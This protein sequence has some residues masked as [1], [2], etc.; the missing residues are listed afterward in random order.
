MKLNKSVYGLT[1]LFLMGIFVST[2]S[3]SVFAEPSMI[4]M[5]RTVKPLREI[6][7]SITVIDE[8][9]I[10]KKQ[11]TTVLD[12]LRDVPALD[13][14]QNGGIGQTSSVFIRGARSEQTL[15]LIDGVEAND[16]SS[17]SRGYN[18]A[19]LGTNN[20]QRIEI[21]RGPQ[22]TLYGSDAIGGVI[23]IITK[24]GEGAPHIGVSA[25][26]G[27]FDTKKHEAN[28]QGGTDIV[29]Y[30]VSALHT[31]S[32]GF[33]AA[34]EKDGN[35]ENDGYE[36]T[37][38]SAKLGLSPH[39]VFNFDVITR[40]AKSIS[41]L[42][43]A[44]GVGGDDPNYVANNEALLLRTQANLT[45]F[46][47]FWDQ[48]VGISYTNHDRH[49]DNPVDPD[50]PMSSLESQFHGRNVKADWQNNIRLHKTNL[51]TI[52]L[53]R[54]KERANTKSLSVSFFGPFLSEFKE[55][56]TDTDS[57]FIQDQF[58][59]GDS[60]FA[61]AGIRLD[62]HS[63]FGSEETHR[64]TAAYLLN[65]TGTKLKTTY[66]TGFKAP[67]LFQLFS[68]FGNLNLNPET[69]SSW[70]VGFEQFI[71]DELVMVAATYFNNRY[72]NLIDFN[73][74]TLTFENISEATSNGVELFLSIA[75]LSNL[76]FSANH[77]FTDTEDK[78]TG[79][80]LVRRPKNKTSA[81]LNYNY[82]DGANAFLQVI[83]VGDRDDFDFTTFPATRVTL[84]AYTVVN[85][86]A[87]H[88]L[89]QNIELFGRVENIFDD[90][91]EEVKG[92]GT[93][94]V[95]GFGGVRLKIGNDS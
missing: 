6:A 45:L 47:D 7:G 30:S 33:S 41:D 34:N 17:S 62:D 58:N 1:S 75:F 52:G 11:K 19:N 13:I 61:T 42:D 26:V 93:P 2:Q 8:K 9:E 32:E 85:I 49:L 5:T 14:V 10:Q 23:N 74:G 84:D 67:T 60:F 63:R 25:E 86:G 91:Y 89:T 56:T 43:N 77:T 50:H 70:D 81:N 87:T 53:E 82:I 4:T 94:G 76:N 59:L 51:L 15:V 57:L 95:S 27:S 35:K 65:H 92:F 46:D 83:H 40:F 31:T 20:I 54:E 48:T 90:E 66:G 73:N 64:L 88:P 38:A 12:L 44:G 16:P 72:K 3:I 28:V 69:S 39:E 21:I 29:N 79:L 71:F 37:N 24:K 78:S 18:F 36:I 68:S 22:S 80:E 55:Q